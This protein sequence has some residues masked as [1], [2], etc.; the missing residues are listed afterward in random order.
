MSSPLFDILGQALAGQNTDAIAKQLGLNSEQASSAISMAIPVLVNAL[1]QNAATPGG[2][3]ALQNALT[4]D[5]D[6]SI[7]DNIGGYLGGGVAT[8]IGAKILSHVLGGQGT[9]VEDGISRAAGIDSAT[10]AKL[11][12]LLAPLV[13]GALSRANTQT[14]PTTSVSDILNGAAGRM[15]QA[16][17]GGVLAQILDQ[18]HDGSAFDDVA[19]IGVS[20]LGGLLRG[21]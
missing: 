2:L 18:N 8:A 14:P 1:N 5:H 17:G 6:G 9:Q 10:V 20:V 12:A 11:M 4:R 19:R 15:Q 3:S 21:R 13:L 7:L 16:G